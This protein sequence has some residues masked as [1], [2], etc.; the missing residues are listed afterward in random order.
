MK[1]VFYNPVF[2]DDIKKLKKRLLI[3]K[4]QYNDTDD[5]YPELMEVNQRYW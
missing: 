2:S 3:L 4:E 5:K 1:N